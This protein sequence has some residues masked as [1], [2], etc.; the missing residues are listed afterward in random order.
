MTSLRD[1]LDAGLDRLKSDRETQFSAFAVVFFLLAFPA[2]FSYAANNVEAG[3]FRGVDT[4]TINGDLTPVLLAGDPEYIGDGDT[5][6]LSFDPSDVDW[7]ETGRN[8][9][10]V[11]LTMEY[12]ED[13][14]SAGVGCAFPTGGS[15]QA[16][17][18]TGTVLRD[19]HNGT[20][21]GQ[22]QA[23]GTSSHE[24]LVEWYNASL[25]DTTVSDRSE[26]TT[27]WRSSKAAQRVSGPTSSISRSKSRVAAVQDAP[28]RTMVRRS[29]IVWNYSSSTTRST[30][31]SPRAD[32]AT[33]A[34]EPAQVDEVHHSSSDD[35]HDA[36][37]V[38]IGQGL[39]PHD[40]DLLCVGSSSEVPA[41][42]LAVLREPDPYPI[43]RGG[44]VILEGVDDAVDDGFLPC[45]GAWDLDLTGG[46]ER[47]CQCIQPSGE[48]RSSLR[49]SGCSTPDLHEA[50][51]RCTGN[52]RD[53]YQPR[54][55]M[56]M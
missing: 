5:V 13:E 30:L 25:L 24:V 32:Q 26:G 55:A 46:R 33:S 3:G 19:E 45:L 6:S 42:V 4:Y 56:K 27:S 37:E 15:V 16:D 1:R 49:W 9:V 40:E 38:L 39:H 2:Y 22:N 8:V 29:P 28:T 50:S 7:G 54:S 14:T 47:R 35:V 53:P 23:Q 10:A 36:V 51:L 12:S 48:G 44:F 43:D 11:R 41:G 52:S 31:P 17:S 34:L 20:A 18:I 21:T